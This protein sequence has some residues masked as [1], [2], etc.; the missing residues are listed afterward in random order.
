MCYGEGGFMSVTY[1][2]I[3]CEVEDKEYL[4]GLS[5]RSIER[6]RRTYTSNYIFDNIL[7]RREADEARNAIG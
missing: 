5:T 1:H 3:E 2:T 4:S 7:V 6:Q